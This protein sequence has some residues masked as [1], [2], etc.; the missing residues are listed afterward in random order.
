MNILNSDP[1]N[2]NKVHVTGIEKYN[3]MNL[4]E[5]I[6][7]KI[8]CNFIIISK[9]AK[10]LQ[11]Q[12]NSCKEL[13]EKS[14]EYIRY[15]R[16]CVLCLKNINFQVLLSK[17]ELIVDYISSLNLNQLIYQANE[18]KKSIFRI[19]ENFIPKLDPFNPP[20]LS[21]DTVETIRK[22]PEETINSERKTTNPQTNKKYALRLE[23]EKIR[24]LLKQ[25]DMEIRK[26]LEMPSTH[27]TEEIRGINNQTEP[28]QMENTYRPHY[29]TYPTCRKIHR[30][31]GCQ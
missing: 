9:N 1:I 24:N 7:N 14:S 18:L 21:D 19:R 13:Y 27:A 20:R 25:K 2:N 11:T 26:F 28:K 30:V 5:N 8:T 22:K 16:S 10:N 31:D 6:V 12:N 3:E 15:I 17:D 4:I 23:N 29:G